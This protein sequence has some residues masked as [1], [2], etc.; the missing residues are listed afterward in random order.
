M[1]LSRVRSSAPYCQMPDADAAGMFLISAERTDKDCRR[2]GFGAF[3]STCLRTVC[4]CKDAVFVFKR[5]F[6]NGM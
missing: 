4:F 1:P 2:H 6:V 5:N 3:C